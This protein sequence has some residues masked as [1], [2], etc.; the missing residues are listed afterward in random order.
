MMGLEL[1]LMEECPD[2]TD[3]DSEAESQVSGLP[4]GC[5]VCGESPH[6]GVGSGSESEE[7]GRAPEAAVKPTTKKY[8][9]W[10]SQVYLLMPPI[11][12]I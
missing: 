3:S 2:G 4:A 1:E 6:T 9:Q 12:P 10:V 7:H 5:S 8:Y 11:S